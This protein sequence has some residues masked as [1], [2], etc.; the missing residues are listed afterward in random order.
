[1]M[2]VENRDVFPTDQLKVLIEYQKTLKEIQEDWVILN[3]HVLDWYGL[4]EKTKQYFLHQ[5][6]KKKFID[7]D[8]KN[9]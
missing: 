1:M 6:P 4:T 9:K 5:N 2:S 7:T 3:M 8:Q